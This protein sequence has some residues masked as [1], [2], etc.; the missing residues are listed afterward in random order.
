MFIGAHDLY[1]KKKLRSGEDVVTGDR[2]PLFIYANCK[3][4]PEDPWIGLLRETFSSA[5]G[6]FLS[7]VEQTSDT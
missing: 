6:V 2:W 7:P 1:V 5:Y 4:D 3:Y